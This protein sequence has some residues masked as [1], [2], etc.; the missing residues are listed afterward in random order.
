[1]VAFLPA[2]EAYDVHVTAESPARSAIK[3]IVVIFMFPLL[4]AIMRSLTK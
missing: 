4:W 1:M 2:A 3:S